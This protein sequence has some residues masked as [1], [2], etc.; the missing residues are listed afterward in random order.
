MR[1]LKHLIYFESLLE[2]ADNDL[3]KQAQAEGKLAIG[4]T[5]TLRVNRVEETTVTDLEPD[6]IVLSANLQADSYY[7]TALQN[8]PQGS[9]LTLTV[10][11]NDGWEDVEYAIGAL[12]CLAENGAVVPNLAAGSNPRT[13]VGQKA[14]GTLVFYTIDGRKAGHSIGASLT[15]VG[16]RLLELGC[17]TVLCLSLIHI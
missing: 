7:T 8:I 2:N 12:Y 15:Q 13:A 5:V 1:D 10:S 17:Q 11:A 9:E 14:D 16:E 6:Q 3:V 4:S